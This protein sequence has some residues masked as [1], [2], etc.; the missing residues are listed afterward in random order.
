MHTC[1]LLLYIVQE[2]NAI[3]NV[4]H[5]H[6]GIHPPQAQQIYSRTGVLTLGS[7]LPGQTSPNLERACMHFLIKWSKTDQMGRCAEHTK[8]RHMCPVPAIEAYRE[9][10]RY[11][12]H[13]STS[14]RWEASHSHPRASAP[15]LLLLKLLTTVYRVFHNQGKLF[16]N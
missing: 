6:A 3:R 4:Q 14:K 1:M 16:I 15:P 2:P 5:L 7:T 12:T 11:S 13:S 9:C 10:C 8:G